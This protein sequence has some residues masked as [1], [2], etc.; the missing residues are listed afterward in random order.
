MTVTING[1]TGLA[2]DS[3]SAVVE[4][5]SLN[6]PSSSTAAITMDAS[7]N[8]TLAS[9]LTMTGG[10]YLGGTGSGNLI[11]DYEQ[12]SFTVTVKGYLANPSTTQTISGYYT[13][14]GRQVTVYAE[15]LV[16]INTTGASGFIYFEGLPFATSISGIGSI[17]C[18]N[19]ATFS[20]DGGLVSLFTDNVIYVYENASNTYWRTV[21]HNPNST[22]LFKISGTYFTT[23]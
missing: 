3:T 21:N 19:G 15:N 5:V 20:Y 12:G 4:A 1:T 10:V 11:S 22:V 8:V 16:A 2:T 14:I 17:M 13:K 9:N 6:H 23:E 7:N 18:Y